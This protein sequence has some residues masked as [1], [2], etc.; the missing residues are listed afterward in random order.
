MERSWFGRIWQPSRTSAGALIRASVAR[1]PASGGGW[2]SSPSVMRTRQ[3]EQRPRPPQ[4]ATCGIP[5]E[6][7]ASSS[8]NPRATEMLRPS[9]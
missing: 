5:A 7:L 3:V 8:E 9:G 6:R 1:S 2:P 4:T